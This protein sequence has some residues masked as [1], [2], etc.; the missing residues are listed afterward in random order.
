MEAIKRFPLFE[1]LPEDEL[2][3]LLAHSYTENLAAGESFFKENGPAERFYIVLEGE[4]QV[5]RNIDGQ[6]MVLGTNPPGI[7]GGELSL[8]YGT[9]SNVTAQAILPSQLLVLDKRSFRE[10]FS[11]CP[12]LGSR[13]FRTAIERTQ[14][15]AS[16][17]KQQ[18]KMA[19]LGK[20]SAGLAHELNNP[21]AAALRAAK[22]LAELLPLVQA[23]S[24]QVNSSGLTEQ[25]LERLTQLQLQAVEHARRKQPLSALEQSDRETELGDWLSEQGIRQPWEVASAFVSAG[26]TLDELKNG[27]ADLSEGEK[28]DALQWLHKALE[29]QH[30][31]NEIQQSMQRI[32]ELVSA[33]K[34]YTYMDQARLIEVD[35]HKDLENT[36]TVLSHKLKRVKVNRQYDPRLPR[37]IARG[38]ELNQVWTNLIDNAIDAMQ[39]QGELS[40]ITRCE[41]SFV[42]VEVTD[43]GAGISPELLPRLFEPFFTTKEVGGGTGLGLDI[44]YRIVKGHN[45]TIE[46]Q[47]QP[48]HT[49]FIVRLPMGKSK[50]KD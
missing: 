15:F 18:E 33:I 10:L 6:E 50:P 19:A 16:V 48:G 17:V 42:M 31:L 39:G 2:S 11:T 23:Q 9:P 12:S 28:A 1:G 49:R 38:G 21:A 34:A 20:L 13:I 26:I 24:L 5:T 3:W 44:S 45:G 47:S 27:A 4:L 14:G 29:A 32:S 30:L 22:N 25:Q 35:I 40:L 37:L 36:L 7:M 43:N 8:L 41:N 46:V